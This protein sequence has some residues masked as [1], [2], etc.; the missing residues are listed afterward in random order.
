M[1]AKIKD[2][3]GTEIEIQESRSGYFRMDFKGEQFTELDDKLGNKI[4]CCISLNESKA[5]VLMAALEEY[6]EEEK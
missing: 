3:Y 1:Y 6:F 2:I 4:T 5:R